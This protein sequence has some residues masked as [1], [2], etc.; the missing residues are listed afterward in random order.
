MYTM[1]AGAAEQG[2]QGGGG[3]GGGGQLPT[4]LKNCGAS[5]PPTEINVRQ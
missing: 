4:Q 1:Y 5:P 2:G 3:G